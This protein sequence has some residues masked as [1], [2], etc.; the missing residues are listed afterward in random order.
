MPKNCIN[1]EKNNLQKKNSDR[2]NINCEGTRTL[3]VYNLLE[4]NYI[5][6]QLNNQNQ[7][8]KSKSSS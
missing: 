5:R 7:N 4:N 6:A 2:S 3:C 1:L 8:C